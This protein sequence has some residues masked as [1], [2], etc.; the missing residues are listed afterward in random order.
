[1]P[2]ILRI[3]LILVTTLANGC[4]IVTGLSNATDPLPASATSNRYAIIVGVNNYRLYPDL[5]YSVADANLLA[6]TLERKGY[7]VQLLNNYDADPDSVLDALRMTGQLMRQRGTDGTLIFAFSGHGFQQDGTNY[8]AMGHAD[9]TQLSLTALSMK[10]VKQ[11]LKKHVPGKRVLFIDACRNDPT[12]SGREKQL[13]F[14]A[15]TD[16]EG[17]AILYGTAAGAWAWE[18]PEIKHGVFSYHLAKALDTESIAVNDEITFTRL[19]TY[20]SNAVSAHV[21]RRF[22]E[23]QTPYSAGERTGTFV[24]AK[25]SLGKRSTPSWRA[26]M[27]LA[28]TVAITAIVSGSSSSGGGDGGNEDE[29]VTLVVPTP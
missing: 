25:A 14:I 16:A 2:V 18:D 24:I 27:I 6:K 21:Y 4:S 5:D 3:L 28:G 13:N 22:N 29:A 8:L 7:Q 1:M 26:L 10:R 17:L 20:V 15:D 23:V 11:V 12:K 19:A 9:G